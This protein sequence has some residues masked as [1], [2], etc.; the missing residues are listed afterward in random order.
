MIYVLK[1]ARENVTREFHFIQKSIIIISSMYILT[2]LSVI[3][4]VVRQQK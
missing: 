3:L 4:R 1:M 2:V